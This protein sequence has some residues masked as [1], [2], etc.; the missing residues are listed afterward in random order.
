MEFETGLFLDIVVIFGAAF[1]G[2]LAARLLRLPVIL[3]YLIVGMVIGPHVMQGIDNTEDV[4]TLAEFGVI[5]LVFTVGIE[6]SFRQLRDLGRAVLM[7]AVAQ[8]TATVGLG[9]AIATLMDWLPD[10]ALVFGL[11]VS[12]SSTMVVLKTLSDRGE[13]GS[14]HGRLLT[15]VLLIQDL[16]F[17]P[18]MAVLPA[19]GGAPGSFATDFL[20]G[21]GKAAG[22]LIAIGLLGGKAI[23]WL[24]TRV[25]HLG[26]REVFIL[27]LVAITFGTAAITHE[28][29]LS[30]ALG[31]FVAGLILSESEFGYRAL[32]E[33]MPLRDTFSALFFVSLGM[34]M[35]P[36]FLW[37]NI[38]LILA[39]VAVSVFVKFFVTAGAS[40]ASG[41]LPQTSL[42]AGL[43]GVQIGEFSFILA[44]SAVA[45]G[46]VD[47]DFLSLV[48]VSAVV[49]MAFTPGIIAL[50]SIVLNKSSHRFP[51]MVAKE[52]QDLGKYGALYGHAIICGMDRVGSLVAQALQ[53]HSL[54][55]VG[56]DMDPRV[57]AHS[58]DQ[59]LNIIHGSSSSEHILMVANV[60]SARLMVISTG[61][62]VSTWVTAH[63]ALNLNPELEV[64][65]RVLGRDEGDELLRLGVRE[66]VWPAMEAGLE[67]LRH[68][69]GL[70][71]TDPEEVEGLVTIHREQLSF[72]TEDQEDAAVPAHG[73]HSG[74]APESADSLLPGPKESALDD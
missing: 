25:A 8:I 71:H 28:V 16:A 34:L 53:D 6:V 47:N 70:Y 17:V 27:T 73:H 39:V 1:L 59:G 22:I 15:G 66:V 33:V 56:I 23:P 24:L 46:V 37:D 54:P 26:S 35:D 48:V 12:L 61:D 74:A 2:G 31:A 49:T 52:D 68:S 40:L 62:S 38:G 20:L 32:S 13:L 5:L 41:Y 3:G 64:I 19:L 51:A 44:A 21:V 63:H 72:G 57:V 60:K 11:V 58:R 55:F 69:L 29:G 50:G 4:Q 30:A 43:G 42:M 36:I 45:L 14:L 7:I 18:M 67:I 65:A 9:F 10:K